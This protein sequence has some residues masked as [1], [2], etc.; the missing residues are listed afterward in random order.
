MFQ[1]RLELLQRSYRKVKVLALSENNDEKEQSL[2]SIGDLIRQHFKEFKPAERKIA[3]HLIENYP[4]AGMVSI[5]ELSSA[6]GVSTPTVMRT[7]KRIGYTSFISFQKALKEELVKTLSDPIAKH[8]LWATGTPKEHI[9]NQMADSVVSNL[10]STMNHINFDTFNDVVE[11]LSDDNKAVYLTGGR[12]TSPFAN[13]F[14][15]HLEVIRKNVHQLPNSVSLWAHHLLDVKR[16]DVLIV[17]DIRRYESD[18]LKLAKIADSK[19]VVIILFTDQ[20]L[21]PIV[22]YATHSFPVLIEA[23]SGW[24]SAVAILFVIEAL[25]AAIESKLWPSALKRMNEL[26]DTFNFTGRF[27]PELSEG[28][29]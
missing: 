17:F 22:K 13:S 8:D 24:D 29:K 4:M 1:N 20:W 14:A 26:E 9:L 7:L 10:K 3:T 23:P 21:S 11:L 16:G 2:Q 15:I 18:F 28:K 6:C 25:V 19:G 27:K 5:T 12:I